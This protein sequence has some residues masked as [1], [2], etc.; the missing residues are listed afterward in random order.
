MQDNLQKVLGA[1]LLQGRSVVPFVKQCALL[2]RHP[3]SQA[4]ASVLNCVLKNHA[5]NSSREEVAD[6][7]NRRGMAETLA[8]ISAVVRVFPA[9]TTEQKKPPREQS[10]RSP[11]LSSFLRVKFVFSDAEGGCLSTLK[12]R[13][14]SGYEP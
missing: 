9:P 1:T 4:K 6:Q 3:H 14:L 7:V 11:W 13:V 10:I 2:V 8:P 12:G 5:D